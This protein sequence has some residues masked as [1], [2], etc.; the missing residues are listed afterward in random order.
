MVI[1]SGVKLEIIRFEETRDFR[2]WQSRVN[3]LLAQ[4][5]LQKTLRE[6][7]SNNIENTDR[8]EM[9]EKS[10]CLIYLWVSDELMYHI[11]NLTT[12]EKV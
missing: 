3:D 9:N 7:K 4:Q 11:L 5:C 2:L 6:M 10:I 12:L 8:V 1:N